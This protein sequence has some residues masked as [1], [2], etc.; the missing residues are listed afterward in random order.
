VTVSFSKYLHWQATHF[1][2]A[3]HPLLE[4]VLQTVCRKLQEE[5]RSSV[6]TVVKAQKLHG[7]RSGLY[8]ECS[9]GVP[10][11][12]VR[13]SIAT[14]QSRNADAPLRLLCHC[15]S[16]FEKWVGR[17]KKC[18]V[19]QGRYFEKETVTAPLQSSTRSNWVSSRTLQM[20]LVSIF[21]LLLSFRGINSVCYI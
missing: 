4:N 3:L 1:F 16:V 19:C 6:F 21:C 14:F 12:S 15:N 7:A 11:I 9:N 5:T 8:D 10:P 18:F 2:T 20:A 13:V 17:C